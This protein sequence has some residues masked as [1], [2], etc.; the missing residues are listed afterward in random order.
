MLYNPGLQCVDDFL[1]ISG[2]NACQVKAHSKPWIVSLKVRNNLHCAGTLIRSELVL[3]AA[4]CVCQCKTFEGVK[5]V[6]LEVSP[7]CNGW[8]KISVIAGDHDIENLDEGEQTIAV[9]HG[10]VHDKWQ[11]TNVMLIFRH[12]YKV[13]L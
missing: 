5:C 10:V 13:K 1:K 4:H 2:P 7:N 11:G 8:R 6:K 3:T 12:K 9:K